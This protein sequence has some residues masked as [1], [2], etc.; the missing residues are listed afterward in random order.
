MCFYDA[1]VGNAKM[2]RTALFFAFWRSYG[3]QDLAAPTPPNL[4]TANSSVTIC[5]TRFGNANQ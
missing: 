4:A 3:G 1:V 2:Q 5:E